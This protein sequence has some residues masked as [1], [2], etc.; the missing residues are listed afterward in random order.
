MRVGIVI[1]TLFT[2]PAFLPIAASS[3]SAQIPKPHLMLGCPAHLTERVSEAAGGIDA[4]PEP[5][6]VPL[7]SKINYLLN[8]LPSECKYIGWLGDD[9]VLL[10]GAIQAAVGILDDN[11]EVVM[12]YGGCDYVSAEGKVLFT[13]RSSRFAAKLMR[14][15]PQL[16]PQPG[17]LWRREAF[18]LVGGLSPEFNMAFDYDLFLK[19]SKIG[20][21]QHVPQTLAQFRWHSGSLS[22]RNRTASVFEASRVRKKH[23]RGVM[24]LIWPIWEPLVMFATWGAGWLV[25][26]R[27]KVK[28]VG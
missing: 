7:A 15:G 12:V 10:P 28:M 9:D 6:D 13:N 26:K 1:P 19:L 27:F 22:V 2:R 14:F 3:V 4:T 8:N 11:P 21:L 20:E 23:Y 25:S 18:E 24:R 5:V 16:I 17:S